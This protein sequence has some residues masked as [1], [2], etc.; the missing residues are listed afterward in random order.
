MKKILILN[1]FLLPFFV[2]YAAIVTLLVS[3]VLQLTLLVV[4][5]AHT[6]IQWCSYTNFYTAY[7]FIA[8]QVSCAP[9][10]S[11]S[12]I[13]A[14]TEG[15]MWRAGDVIHAIESKE[16]ALLYKESTYSNGKWSNASTSLLVQN[17]QLAVVQLT[18]EDGKVQ[19]FYCQ[20]VDRKSVV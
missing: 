5:V 13:K 7:D 15:F 14:D 11:A 8:R 3:A 19:E 10:D 2:I 4:P 17:C 9:V 1:G 12:W 16:G 18:V 6:L 20:A